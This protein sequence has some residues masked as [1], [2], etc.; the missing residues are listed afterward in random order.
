MMTFS[1]LV[2]LFMV[3]PVAV[4]IG[5]VG[6][7]IYRRGGGRG[8]ANN[9]APTLSIP[10]VAVAKRTEIAHDVVSGRTYTKYYVT[11]QVESGD[12]MELHAA[13]DDYGVIVEDDFGKLTFRG[14]E[15]VSFER[16]Q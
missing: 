9:S 7:Y 12:R 16:Q 8:R 1:L 10:A 11:F 4:V 14:N 6:G 2:L 15:L 5:L 13:G 3:L